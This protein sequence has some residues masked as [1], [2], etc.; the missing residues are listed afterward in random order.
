MKNSGL[1][2]IVATGIAL[3]ALSAAPRVHAQVPEVERQALI[4]L[5]Q[6]TGGD[7]WVRNDGWLGPEGTECDWFGISCSQHE[8]GGRRVTG[9]N[10]SANNLRGR[11]PES[12]G[13]LPELVSL[14][15][16]RN[17]LTG[18]VPGSL[19][20]VGVNSIAG[21]VIDLSDNRLEGFGIFD[22]ETHP[23]R[24]SRPFLGFEPK[25]VVLANNRI[26]ELPGAGWGSEEADISSLMLSGNQI[27]DEV[28]FTETSWPSLTTLDLSNNLIRGGF[29]F[30]EGSL[31][32][33][34]TLDLSNN[35]VRGEF[36]F[37]EDPLP[38][39]ST[40]DLSNNEITAWQDPVALPALWTLRLRDNSLARLS[41]DVLDG[42]PALRE[43]D[44]AD[45]QFESLDFIVEE[46][47]ELVMLDLTGNRLSGPIP[48]EILEMKNLRSSEGIAFLDQHLG[49][50][51]LCWND[52]FAPD[53]EVRTFVRAHH[54]GV[55]FELC[56]GRQ[57]V[58][59]DPGFSGTYFTPARDGEFVS[60]MQLD[61]GAFLLFQFTFDAE[62]GQRWRFGVVENP[63]RPFG[64]ELDPL[65][66]S[67]GRF[68]VGYDPDGVDGERL[69]RGFAE[70]DG[71]A[72]D[73]LAMLQGRRELRRVA[74]NRPF[75]FL[76][77]VSA[78]RLEYKP[79]TR[80]AGT[81]CDNAGPHQWT[82][83]LWFDPQRDGDGFLVEDL[84]DGRALV[85]WWTHTP[86]GS[87]DQAW[88][89]GV[90]EYD[91][92]GSGTLVIDEVFQPVGA[93]YGEEF[94]SEDLRVEPWGRMRL[95]FVNPDSAE[96]S[97]ISDRAEYGAGSFSLVPLARPRLADCPPE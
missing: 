82:S 69:N 48:R 6:A 26:R 85:F 40:L 1:F 55:N 49:G 4:E 39:L 5:Y 2:A 76:R 65:F 84:G 95:R 58:E 67:E 52:L 37:S 46:R 47:T 27:E 56:Q 50:L 31:P 17:R 74:A 75:M 3:A 22:V 59:L 16:N 93:R 9:M 18:E 32:S 11:I 30:A 20:N 21:V 19:L 12:L 45:N 66:E 42:M 77:E 92:P 72:N 71:L 68:A 29:E 88:M 7:D 24:G 34:R 57:R 83:G 91:D 38:S 73:K 43:L 60:L 54:T 15:L 94:D 62:G 51:R 79:L 90:G 78:Q 80:I 33:L 8:D 25:R 64:V 41:A 53:E 97:W 36:E 86:D 10:L 70:I 81:R 28:V 35:R 61:R 13:S 96:I 63:V 14:E 87:G 23:D 89:F 44:A